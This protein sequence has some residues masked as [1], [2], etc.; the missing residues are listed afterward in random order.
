VD[1]G[2]RRAHGIEAGVKAARAAY[3]AGAAS[4]S[5]LL[6]G[7]SYGL[8]VAGTMAH[9]YVLAHDDELESFRRFAEIYPQTV[10]L[11]DTYD[12]LD[13]VRKVVELSR[14]LGRQFQVRG[15]RIDSGDL[16]A[17]SRE[18]RTILDRAGL[19]QVS[20]F[21]SGDLDEKRIADL[22]QG[23]APF[24]AFGVGTHLVTS[25]DAPF[26][27]CAYKLVEYAGMPRMK[28]STGKATLP[29]RKQIFRRRDNS[30][31]VGD[32]IARQDETHPGE[33]MLQHVMSDGRRLARAPDLAQARQYCRTQIASL[34]VPVIEG[35]A[36]YAVTVSAE[37]R[38]ET[39]QVQAGLKARTW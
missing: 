25:A 24:D 38:Q 14:E 37:L 7:R 23:K 22:V 12:T 28:L 32:L 16:A 4:S 39:E 18:A 35:G 17:L 2:L 15:I 26:L 19:E 5:D 29:G 33:R 27:N 6:A 36:D 9:S 8:P 10:L 31:C 11:V 20:I 13:G 1:F 3:L 21:A 34:P 30:H